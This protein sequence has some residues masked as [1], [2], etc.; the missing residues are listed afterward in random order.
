MP[1]MQTQEEQT[2]EEPAPEPQA[3]E[4]RAQEPQPAPEPVYV[5]DFEAFH[6]L[7]GSTMRI[8][9]LEGTSQAHHEVRYIGFIKGKS[10]LVTLPLVNDK[11]MWMRVGETFVVRGFNGRHA[12]AFTT[13]VRRAREHPYTYVHFTYPESVE[14]RLVRRTLR[15]SVSIPATIVQPSAQLTGTMLDLSAAGAMVELEQEAGKPG[16]AIQLKFTIAM[17]E[18][19]ADM[20]MAATIRNSTPAGD[21]KSVRTGVAFDNVSQ[22]DNLIL[23][24]YIY[25]LARLP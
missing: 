25:H 21:G 9:S 20:N 6:L 3:Q 23:H 4:S 16:D 19:Q 7:P 22:Q 18:H 17:D 1:K 8:Q 24:Y 10:I 14:S 2:P 13:K 15:V 5:S 12:Y 11:G